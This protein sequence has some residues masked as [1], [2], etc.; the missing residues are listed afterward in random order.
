MV[1][2][3]SMDVSIINNIVLIQT[4]LLISQI[5]VLLCII[6]NFNVN[7]ITFTCY[8]LFSLLLQRFSD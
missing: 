5:I 7:C 8:H 4:W 3:E 6:D 1:I 2:F